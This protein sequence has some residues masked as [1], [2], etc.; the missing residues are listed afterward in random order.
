M[1]CHYFDKLLR[2]SVIDPETTQNDWLVKEA[3]RRV[4]DLVSLCL[5]FGSNGVLN[6]ELIEDCVSEYQ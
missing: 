5:D 4:K 1:I 6:M 2:V 3:K